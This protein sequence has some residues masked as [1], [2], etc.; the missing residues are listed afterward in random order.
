MKTFSNFLCPIIYDRPH[1][2]T[3]SRFQ[4]DI[5]NISIFFLSFQ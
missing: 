4:S 1:V 5:N 2:Y 3:K